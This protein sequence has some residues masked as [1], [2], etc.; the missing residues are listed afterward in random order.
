MLNILPFR[1]KILFQIQHNSIKTEIVKGEQK[2]FIMRHGNA[3]LFK[4]HSSCT[5]HRLDSELCKFA[6]KTF[7]TRFIG[8][9]LRVRVFIFYLNKMISVSF[10]TFKDKK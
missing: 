5:F 6:C 4:V 2:R 7:S 1:Q 9:T 3:V 10:L 8:D